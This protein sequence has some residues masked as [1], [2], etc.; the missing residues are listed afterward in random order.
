MIVNG[1]FDVDLI[2]WVIGGTPDSTHNI[3]W[4]NGTALYTCGVIS[5]SVSLRQLNVTTIGVK[6]RLTLDNSITLG[7]MKTTSF[8]T[9][10]L[11]DGYNTVDGVATTALLEITRAVADTESNIDN[12]SVKEVLIVV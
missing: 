1:G 2:G 6:Y 11:I 12:V 7:Q 5:P 9:H 3:I 8:G 10:N 4:D